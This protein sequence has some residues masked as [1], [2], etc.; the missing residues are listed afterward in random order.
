MLSTTFEPEPTAAIAALGSIW[1]SH[2]PTGPLPAS[3][4][5]RRSMYGASSTR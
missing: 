3:G 5:A 2:W 1:W 4:I